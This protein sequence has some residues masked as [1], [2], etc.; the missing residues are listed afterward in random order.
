[1]KALGKSRWWSPDQIR[2]KAQE[3]LQN[4]DTFERMLL[5]SPEEV[6]GLFSQIDELA[7]ALAQTE[8]LLPV[9]DDPYDGTS[10]SVIR[11]IVSPALD[12]LTT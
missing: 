7:G 2:A 1:M 4:P 10:N 5:L 8:N 6:L 11:G 3:Q 9:D 12:K